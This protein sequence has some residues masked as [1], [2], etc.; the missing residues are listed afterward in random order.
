M[1][2]EGQ[3]EEEKLREKVFGKMN[4]FLKEFKL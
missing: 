1:N 4:H 2:E 3:A